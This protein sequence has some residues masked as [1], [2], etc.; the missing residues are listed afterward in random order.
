MQLRFMQQP[1]L[2]AAHSHS[3]KVLIK[4]TKLWLGRFQQQENPMTKKSNEVRGEGARFL[5]RSLW[6][7]RHSVQAN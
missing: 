2:Q 1:D 3:S 7:H 5:F 6:D 4:A